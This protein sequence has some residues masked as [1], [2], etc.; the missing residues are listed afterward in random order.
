MKTVR[1]VSEISKVSVRTLHYYDE[2]GLLKPSSRT[3]S[4]YRLYDDTALVRLGQILLYRELEFSLEEIRA[5]LSRPDFERVEALRQ[6]EKMLNLR[7]ERL[8]RLIDLARKLQKEEHQVV[9]FE[10]FDKGELEQY[11]QEVRSCWGESAAYKEYVQKTKHY[12]K[13]QWQAA[14]KGLQ[15]CFLGFEQLVGQPPEAET[16]Q[17]QVAA[18]QQSITENYYCCTDGILAWLGQMYVADERF[19][20]N[21][22]RNKKG[23]AK[24]VSEAIAIYCKKK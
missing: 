19:L 21:I 13:E 3:Q 20:N 7:R 9:D 16:V 6:Q 15:E 18:L 5:I 22:D 2:I 1:E 24:L 12:E 23:T 4:G 8:T 14:A 11:E 10:A 17:K